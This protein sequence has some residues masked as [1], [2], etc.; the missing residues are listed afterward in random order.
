MEEFYE[1]VLSRKAKVPCLTYFVDS[2]N[3]M[4]PLSMQPDKIISFGSKVHL[5]NGTG[6]VELK[7]LNNLKVAF[8]GGR[9][10][11]EVYGTEIIDSM[12]KRGMYKG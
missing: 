11:S 5:L 12:N 4:G 1:E 9:D 8:V 3:A 7:E 2:S 6:V 10:G